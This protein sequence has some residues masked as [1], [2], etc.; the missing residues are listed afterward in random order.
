MA[1]LE[2]SAHDRNRLAS[3]V[4]A[5]LEN[6]KFAAADPQGLADRGVSVDDIDSTS[7]AFS[8][9]L[10]R[11]QAIQFNTKACVVCGTE[12]E[13]TNPRKQTC[14]DACRQALSR[15]KR[16]KPIFSVGDLV[17]SRKGKSHSFTVTK[18]RWN[19]GYYFVTG[20]DG[21]GCRESDLKR[22]KTSHTTTVTRQ[23]PVTPSQPERDS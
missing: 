18:I 19:G 1:H 8:D 4:I 11:L 6:L 20:A 12:F 16:A 10:D 2:L 7:A 9:L 15:S 22:A 3:A 21:T 5:T 17:Q 14:S 13:A 23:E